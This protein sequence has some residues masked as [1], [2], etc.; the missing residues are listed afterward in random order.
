MLQDGAVTN[1][2]GQNTQAV[3]S[4]HKI[5]QLY[6]FVVKGKQGQGEVRAGTE[7]KAAG[8]MERKCRGGEKAERDSDVERTQWP[9]D[10]I[11][12]LLFK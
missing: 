4:S 2:T 6:F 1:P 12:A 8:M 5:Q 7:D 11:R 9:E 10:E 3:K